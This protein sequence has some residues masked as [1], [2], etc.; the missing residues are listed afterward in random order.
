[1]VPF[2]EE[3]GRKAMS[4]VDY[5]KDGR[6]ARVT[7]NRPEVMNAINDELP[8]ELAAAVARADA[9]PGVHVIVLSGRGPAFCAG[10]DLSFYAEGNGSGQATQEMPW[11]PI[12]DYSFMWANTQHFMALWRAMKPVVCKV[13]GFAV[14]G[15]SDIALCADMTIMGESAQIGY[16]PARVWGCPTTAMWVYRLG[17][18]RAKRMLFTGDRI[19]GREAADMGLVLEA[20]PDEALDD[21]V[22]ELAV[23]MASVPINQLAMQKMVINQAIEQTGMMQT[24]RLAT[25]FDGITRHSPEGINFKTRAE[26]VGWKQAVTERDKGT[27]DWTANAELPRRNR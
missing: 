25:L 4:V 23:R 13:Q 11:D 17:A 1:M 21:R 18:E 22:E 5:E 26:A 6:I 8:V 12:K 16:M 14:A 7:L 10:Y 19:T 24:Q 20:V 3:K 9:D 2:A 15:G 27:W